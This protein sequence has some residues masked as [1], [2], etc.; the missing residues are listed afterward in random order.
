MSFEEKNTWIYGLTAVLGAAAYSAIVGSQIP[1]TP[2]TEIDY[3]V[4]MIAAIVGSVVL[5]ILLIIV[6]SIAAPSE[7][8]KRDERDRQVNTRGDQVGF[9]VLSLLALV[10]L[11]L[12]F[13]EAEHFW[14]ANSLYLAFVATAVVSSLVKIYAY[15][16][17][18]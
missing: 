8:D 17:G 3:V 1:T 6:I 5:S 11:V 2:V 16:R 7:A 18:F 4:P 12:A 14:I 15:R 10:P 9:Y 13:A